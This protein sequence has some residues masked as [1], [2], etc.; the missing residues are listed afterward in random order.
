[1]FS[2]GGFQT[3]VEGPGH[4]PHRSQTFVIS[5]G[6]GLIVYFD[7]F[8]PASAEEVVQCFIIQISVVFLPVGNDVAV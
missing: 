5:A 6:H 2:H 8:R 4:L 7:K 3:A 1:M